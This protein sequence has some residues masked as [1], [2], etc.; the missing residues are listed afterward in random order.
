MIERALSTDLLS[1]KESPDRRPLVLRGARQVGKSYLVKAF[2]KRHFSNFIDLNFELRPE[3]KVLFKERNVKSILKQ[4]SII[5][6]V[7]VED[8]K[9]LLFLDEIQECPQAFLSLRYFFEETPKIAVIGAG[10]LLDSMLREQP[11]DLRI[12]VGRIEYRYLHPLSF[13]E[14]LVAVGRDRLAQAISEITLKEPLSPALHNEALKSF[15]NYIIVGGMPAAVDAWR[16]SN[17]GARFQEIQASILQTYQDDFRK[18]KTRTDLDAL[19]EVYRR[20]PN[21]VCRK[22]KYSEIYP[23][24]ESR[25]ARRVLDLFEM[26]RVITKV[27]VSSAN[28][29]PL[30]AEANLMRFKFLLVDIG[31]LSNLLQLPPIELANWNIDLVNSGQIAEQVVGQELL[32]GFPS[33]REPKLYYW[34]RETK[35]SNAEV[36]Y[37]FGQDAEV[38]PLEVKA[39]TTGSLKSLQIF[40]ATKRSKIGV[41]ISQHQLSLHE[42]ILSVPIY[43]V[44]KLTDLIRE[45]VRDQS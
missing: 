42:K 5:F 38:F 7:A 11:D 13:M 12:P 6:D 22:F 4:L 30:E 15:S 23:A 10:S 28:G 27:T 31:L 34:S 1:W 25:A 14:Y 43:A 8:D 29:L 37:V 24:G 40:L 3:L 45:A 21:H 35:G 9:T 32:T 39:G 20:L 41:R 17:R 2:A 26:A 33:Y 19:E 36:D 44:S 18:Y 16:S